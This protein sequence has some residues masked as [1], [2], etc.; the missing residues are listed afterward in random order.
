[1]VCTASRAFVDKS[2]I[3]FGETVR[4]D[5]WIGNDIVADLY[6]IRNIVAVGILNPDGER[7]GVSEVLLVGSGYSIRPIK[8]RTWEE[9][10]HWAE[11]YFAVAAVRLVGWIKLCRYILCTIEL[12]KSVLVAIT[13]KNNMVVDDKTCLNWV[14]WAPNWRK[15]RRTYV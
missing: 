13:L 4:A 12:Q 3:A 8:H 1:M 15:R 14:R 5:R 2:R 6:F 9:G 7:E 11:T 10:R